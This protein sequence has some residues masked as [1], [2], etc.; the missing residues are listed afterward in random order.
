MANIH[1]PLSGRKIRELAR[2]REMSLRSVAEMMA[3]PWTTFWGWLCETANAPQ[4]QLESL[5]GVLDCD[6]KL[7]V[8]RTEIIDL[9]EAFQEQ[10]DYLLFLIGAGDDDKVGELT[11]ALRSAAPYFLPRVY[12][13]G[14]FNVQEFTELFFAHRAAIAAG[15]S[16]ESLSE[17][18]RQLIS[19]MV[20]E[21]E[22]DDDA[23]QA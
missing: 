20:P 12:G 5:A 9:K 10:I 15:E 21:S 8:R 1:L 4:E 7:L 23:E 18:E 17:S 14:S 2:R 6:P 3:V 13:S 16:P 19:Q 11:R 22:S